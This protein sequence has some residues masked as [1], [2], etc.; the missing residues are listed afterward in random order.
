MVA[1]YQGGPFDFLSGDGDIEL[2]SAD[3]IGVDP[4]RKIIKRSEGTLLKNF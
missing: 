1:H 3:Q 4:L 2:V